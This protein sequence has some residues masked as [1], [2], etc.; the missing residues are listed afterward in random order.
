MLF[1]WL[2]L[3]RAWLPWHKPIINP[4]S[5]GSPGAGSPCGC[6]GQWRRAGRTGYSC[7]RCNCSRYL[8]SAGMAVPGSWA[9][10]TRPALSRLSADSSR[11][12]S[13]ASLRTGAIA[14]SNNSS[15][16]PC[17]QRG[18][19]VKN[20][21]FAPCRL[22]AE[23]WVRCAKPR[24]SPSH[25]PVPATPWAPAAPQGPACP[26]PAPSPCLGARALEQLGEQARLQQAL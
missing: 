13:R 21:Q 8:L 5:P 10:A 12:P 1:L 15:C 23:K 19:A 7:G 14:P 2:W 9:A 6:W 11:S 20:Q 17:L 4:T 16:L 18:E 26:V 22:L 3:S 25:T 24:Q